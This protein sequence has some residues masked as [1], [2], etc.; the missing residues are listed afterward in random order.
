MIIDIRGND[1]SY[2]IILIL[3]EKVY[4]VIFAGICTKQ[5]CFL[6]L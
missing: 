5:T 4:G 2:V 1:N 3:V 6:S